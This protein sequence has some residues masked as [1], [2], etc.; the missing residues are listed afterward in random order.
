MSDDTC[1]KDSWISTIKKEYDQ[2]HHKTDHEK[3]LYIDRMYG[4]LL[5]AH[6]RLKKLKS[7]YKKAKQ[8][9]KDNYENYAFLVKN[10]TIL[11]NK[12]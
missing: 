10:P 5:Y 11:S 6:N 7:R 4:E 8:M 12:K 9:A 3:D 1:M 2:I